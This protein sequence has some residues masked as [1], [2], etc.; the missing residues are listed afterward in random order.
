MGPSDETLAPLM[1][2]SKSAVGV[3]RAVS[4]VG[5]KSPRVGQMSSPNELCDSVPA[6]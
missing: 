3:N 4:G 6:T 5:H 1:S 2:S